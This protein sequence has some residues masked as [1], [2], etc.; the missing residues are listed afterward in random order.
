MTLSPL[1]R[2]LAV[3][4]ALAS[5]ACAQPTSD[6][7]EPLA[8]EAEPGRTMAI[9][10]DDLPVGRGHSLAH[11]QRVT[12]DL[13][14][15]IEAAGVPVIGFVNE[16]KLDQGSGER[17]ART[18]LLR[19]WVDAG[20]ELGNHTYG[21]P[22]LFNTPLAEFQDHVVR[23]EPV[24]RV[25]LAARGSAPTDSLRYF[26][27]PYLNVGPDLETKRAFEDWIR[28]RGYTVAPVSHDN[29]EYVYA[30]AYDIA[31]ERGDTDLQARIADAYI[32]YM[33][34][35]AAYFEG[36]SRDLFDR[37]IAG[38]LL[39]H[40]N[41][42]NADHLG[43]L[44][45]AFRARGYRFVPL[46]EALQDPAYTSEDTYVGRAGMS[47]LQRWAIT[48]GVPF[49]SEPLAHEWVQALTRR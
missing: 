17:E 8:P 13:L 26:R 7:A 5:G 36:L 1:A 42:L 33:D 44:V 47:W 4:V 14:A 22:S 41:A 18:D 43:R 31:L 12:R 16:G 11:Q 27:H 45:G 29:A 19:A 30:Y 24:T 34:T 37:E 25:L 28:A 46:G 35:T 40:S 3:A 38:I 21:H 6:G 39:I 48:R 2:G 15:Q 10:I 32:A 23:G 9:T 49:S 20:H